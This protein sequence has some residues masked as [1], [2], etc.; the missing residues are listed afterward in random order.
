MSRS[1]PGPGGKM[2]HPSFPPFSRT[3]CPT[4]LYIHTLLLAFSIHSSS[5][6]CQSLINAVVCA[7]CLIRYSLEPANTSCMIGR[8]HTLSGGDRWISI[9]H[10]NILLPIIDQKPFPRWTSLWLSILDPAWGLRGTG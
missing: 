9:A 5:H 2:P 10:P 6:S 8:M 1:P 7:G 4:D 3:K